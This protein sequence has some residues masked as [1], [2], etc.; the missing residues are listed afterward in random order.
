MSGRQSPVTPELSTSGTPVVLRTNTL[1]V[2]SLPL[3]FFEPVVL[4]A[5]KLHFESYGDVH[6]WAP[7]KA[8]ARV[9]LIYYDEEAAELAK[10]ACD[11]LYV[12]ETGESPATLL[13]VFRA[14]PTPL[15]QLVNPD[16]LRPPELEKNFLISPPGSPPVGWEQIREEPPNHAPL[17]D[18]LIAALK[19]LQ[20][21]REAPGQHGIE[22]LIEP[23]DGGGIRICVEDCGGDIP[24]T[25]D[26]AE[27]G[28]QR[29][30]NLGLISKAKLQ[31]KPAPT[32][33]PPMPMS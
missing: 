10:D 1:V 8:F 14:D 26:E 13:R 4:E 20:L 23:E 27:E 3:S 24:A 2:T 17:A 25:L 12:K 30:Y 18:D 5:L 15:A 22:V 6:T 29:F 32:A 28:E 7:L 31:F 11:N 9:F 19:K 21:Q 16:L 33:M